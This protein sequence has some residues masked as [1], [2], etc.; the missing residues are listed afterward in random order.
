M[1]FVKDGFVRFLFILR[2]ESASER[3][4]HAL[5]PVEERHSPLVIGARKFAAYRKDAGCRERECGDRLD[6]RTGVY[7]HW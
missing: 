3:T 6:G 5:E 2:G 4:F 1:E 7:V